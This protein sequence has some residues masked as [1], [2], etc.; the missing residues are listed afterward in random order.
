ME[1]MNLLVVERDAD[2][3]QWPSIS[4]G[5]GKAVLVLVQ[6]ADEPTLAFH[7]RILQRLQRSKVPALNKVVLLRNGTALPA[8]DPRCDHLLRH[9]SATAKHGMRVYPYGAAAGFTNEA[10]TKQLSLS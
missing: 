7:E 10:L 5:L 4:R 9:L 6:Q 2:W 8:A 3:S 1:P